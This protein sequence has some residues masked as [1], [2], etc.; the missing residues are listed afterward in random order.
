MTIERLLALSAS[1]NIICMGLGALALRQ[2]ASAHRVFTSQALIY[3]ATT[4]GVV[5]TAG[6]FIVLAEYL[7]YPGFVDHVEATVSSIAWLGMHGH[8]FY[9]N[10]TKEGVY[11]LVYGPALYL[12]QGIFLLV[13]PT[14]TGLKLLS[15]AA[16]FGAFSIVFIVVKQKTKSRLTSLL[17]LATLLIQ[18]VP[19]GEFVY[20]TRAEPFLIFLTAAALLVAVKLRPLPAGILIGVLAG[21]ATGFKV[22]GCLYVAPVAF[23]TIARGKTARD[24]MFLTIIIGACAT[25]F[26]LLPFCLNNMSFIGYL[27]YLSVA[28]HHDLRPAALKSNILFALVLLMPIVSILFWRK[29]AIG[30]SEFWLLVGLPISIATAIVVASVSGPYHLLPFAPIC[31]YAIA[32]VS[33]AVEIRGIIAA[34]FLLFFLSFGIEGSILNAHL[35]TNYYRHSRTDPGKIFELQAYLDKFPKAEIGV[36][37]DFHNSDANYRIFSVLSGHALHVDFTAWEDLAYVGVDESVVRRFIE[38]CE[39]PTWILP[40]GKPFTKVSWYTNEPLLSEQF[41]QVFA[42]N[43]RLVQKGRAYQMW[44]CSTSR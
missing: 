37:D 31:L 33:P 2:T 42:T 43:Y 19:L 22:H 10:W 41:R 35:F 26:A 40:L 13:A 25:A 6:Y 17:F 44:K 7:I 24:Q 38:R 29:S 15:V 28:A 34:V 16:L 21:I 4:L 39:V 20:W 1:A 30:S 12:L 18:F 23:M 3:L 32:V 14:I 36:S 5:V 9:P 27:R 11:G 8:P